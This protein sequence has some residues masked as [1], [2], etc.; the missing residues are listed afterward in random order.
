MV[1]ARFA[2]FDAASE[3]SRP[4]DGGHRDFSAQEIRHGKPLRLGNSVGEHHSKRHPFAVRF[5]RVECQL[6][7]RVQIEPARLALDIPPVAPD[8]EH[9]HEGKGSYLLDVVLE[10]L[11]AGTGSQRRSTL[12]PG[13]A[14]E[15]Q[16]EIPN[17]LGRWRGS[18]QGP[19]ALILLDR[20]WPLIQAA[21]NLRPRAEVVTLPQV[22]RH[23]R[24][25]PW[26]G[27]R[28]GPPGDPA[29]QDSATRQGRHT[30]GAGRDRSP[31]ENRG[32]IS[33]RKGG[34]P[35]NHMANIR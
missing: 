31:S 26:P 10:R 5:R 14:A 32:T 25:Q 11:P 34:P 21:G 6:P 16:A 1:I 19:P 12:L 22:V 33:D 27:R 7:D 23:I 29:C 24:P 9:V 3:I 20:E 28:S 4:S 2:K 13:I 8:V 30:P 35:R 17:R 18:G 15:P